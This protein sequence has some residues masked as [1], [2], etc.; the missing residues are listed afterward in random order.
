MAE[1]QHALVLA[2]C[3]SQQLLGDNSP[4]DAKVTR[5]LSEFFSDLENRAARKDLS[6]DDAFMIA[7]ELESSE[8]NAIYDRLVRPAQGTSH[9]TRKKIETLGVNH[10]R[11]LVKAARRFGVSA[12]VLEKLTQ[13]EREGL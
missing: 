1:K 13:L 10:A 2:F 9:L 6:V 7:T 5:N 8:I 12:P 3:A 4:A 11:I